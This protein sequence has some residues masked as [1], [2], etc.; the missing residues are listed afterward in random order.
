MARALILEL[1]G[2]V[3]AVRR[4]T[5]TTWI[6][7]GIILPAAAL[8]GA[9]P[10]GWVAFALQVIG[11]LLVSLF[12]V[13]PE[14]FAR[15]LRTVDAYGVRERDSAVVLTYLPVAA[16]IF[17]LPIYLV[18]QASLFWRVMVHFPGTLPGTG[19]GDA[20]RLSL[21]NLL[22]T[23]LFLDLFDVLNAGLAEQPAGLTGRLIVFVTRLILSVGFVRVA[24]TLIRAAYYRA[25]G[26]G[27]G[28]DVIADLQR[29]ADGGDALQVW[30]LG[31]ELRGDMR[32]TVD[33]LLD[34]V[35]RQDLSERERD[36]A[37]RCLRALRDWA[38]PHMDEM[39]L[40]GD[41]RSHRLEELDA[42]LS[43]SWYRP[44][45]EPPKRRPDLGIWL[46]VIALA[47]AA[48]IGLAPSLL[49]FAVGATAM[50]VLAWLLASPRATYVAAMERGVAPYVP[51]EGLRGAVLAG[52]A[53]LAVSF[54]GAAWGTLWHATQLWPDAFAGLRE[55]AGNRDVLAFILASVVRVQASLSLP[56][57]FGLVEPP[58]EQRPWVGSAL[59]FVLRTG[60]NLGF[61]AVVIT[62]VQVGRDREGVTGL[63]S[64]PDA[65]AMRM[66]ALRGGR[67]SFHLVTYH[68]L[69]VGQRLWEI[70]DG[71]QRSDVKEALSASGAFEWVVGEPSLGEP[72]SP[73]RLLSQC[74]VIEAVRASGRKVGRWARELDIATSDEDVPADIRAKVLSY[75]AV[76]DVRDGEVQRG[77]EALREIRTGLPDEIP[78]KGDVWYEAIAVWA[79]SVARALSLLN[80]RQLQA[81]EAGDDEL[82]DE[83]ARTLGVLSDLDQDRF[84][85]DHLR[86]ELARA[87]T[88]AVT[89]GVAEGVDRL[90]NAVNLVLALAPAHPW[91]DI[92]IVQALVA[93][94]AVQAL[95]RGNSVARE[96]AAELEQRLLRSRDL[97]DDRWDPT[98][99]YLKVHDWRRAEEISQVVTALVHLPPS[100]EQ[101]TAMVR[102][103]SAVEARYRAGVPE[104]L[105]DAV[106]LWWLA[107][108]SASAQDAHS[109]VLVATEHSLRLAEGVRP[110]GGNF[111]HLVA[112]SH[113]VRA[114]ALRALGESERAYEHAHEARVLYDLIG[115]TG[116]PHAEGAVR[117]GRELLRGFDVM[118]A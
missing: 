93:V 4:T 90:Q 95:G 66:E 94:P 18:A 70:L 48:I 3:D 85:V 11:F 76:M 80:G 109:D 7:F 5:V 83:A 8:V 89:K 39:V 28:T 53:V 61:V 54:L 117:Q 41:P 32:A 106:G 19:W 36:D 33:V 45:P 25:H 71:A 104:E 6:G 77:W 110:Q 12:V 49:G 38:L 60:L 103:A 27:R 79:R 56:D 107:A 72:T 57:V 30:H 34:R 96:A 75:R 116:A 67:Y 9:L 55:G 44:D 87:V 22:F 86:F 78:P 97:E 92:L 40:H 26:L 98:A 52:S 15:D 99:M 91:R 14:E 10:L 17:A 101:L 2:V 118:E 114:Q 102:A 50:L 13:W 105:G 81:G 16:A 1:G 51:V 59:T 115:S 100:S 63:V 62:A 112:N 31:R 84:A 21:D 74:L 68:G 64:V 46:S 23:E 108:S 47:C 65:L 20:W 35:D 42:D 82:T 37:Y 69:V 58:F 111:D 113:A 43:S 29:A 24:V 88:L 73:S